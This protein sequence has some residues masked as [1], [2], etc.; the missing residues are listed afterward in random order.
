M[1]VLALLL[2]S[3]AEKQAAPSTIEIGTGGL[4]GSYLPIGRVLSSVLNKHLADDGLALEAIESP[5]SISNINALVA[6]ETPFGIAQADHQYQAV[7]G[8]GE[9]AER[10]PQS[11][12]RAVFSIFVESVTVVAGADTEI[13]SVDGLKGK[14]VDIGLPGSGTR[15]NS[16][17]VLRVANIDWQTDFNSHEENADD[18]LTKFIGGELDAFFYT[19]GHP[20]SEVKFAIRSVRGARVVPLANIEDLISTH[21]Y[22]I[23][24]TLPAELYPSADG[25]TD[26]E[27]VGVNA[28]LL[29]SADVS[30]EMVYLIT[31]TVFDNIETLATR[32]ERLVALLDDRFLDG[33]TAPIH[34]GALKYYREIGLETP[35]N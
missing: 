19:V 35:V 7:N 20:N 28:A 34:P 5:G 33:L 29:T 2:A 21:P 10:G 14:N 18:R 22:F 26:V 30:E 1:L 6:G 25:G 11:D 32:D 17:D 3:C 15:Q 31:K 8:V 27:T 23:R 12:L 13:H 4:R 24:V 9:W 16:I